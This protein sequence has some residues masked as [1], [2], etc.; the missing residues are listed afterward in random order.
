M[1]RMSEAA[2]AASFWIWTWGARRSL[3]KPLQESRRKPLDF[4]VNDPPNHWPRDAVLSGK[5]GRPRARNATWRSH[6][7]LFESLQ[8]RQQWPECQRE[9]LTAGIRRWVP[10]DRNRQ[11]HPADH[12]MRPALPENVRWFKGPK[13]LKTG[14]PPLRI[15]VGAPRRSIK[16]LYYY[17]YYLYCYCYYNYY[18]SKFLLL[19]INCK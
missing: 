4:H 8:S 6:W 15:S 19:V 14:E 1:T 5:M 18:F 2:E 17:Y 7:E 16:K 9:L 3:K 13:R 12:R 11:G 10:K